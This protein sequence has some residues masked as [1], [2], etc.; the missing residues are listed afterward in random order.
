MIDDALD[1]SAASDVIGKNVGD[2]LAEGKP[3]LPL[4]YAM[5]HGNAEQQSLIRQAI[6]EGS[7]DKFDQI[8][9]VIRETGALE[10]T[11]AQARAAATQAKQHIQGL[12][13]SE[14]KRALMFLADYAVD[15]KY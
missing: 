4:I 13:E 8:S 5:Q 15:R 10:Y 6:E 2:D 3:T 12:D 1:Y 7:I 11:F 9:Q 14:Y